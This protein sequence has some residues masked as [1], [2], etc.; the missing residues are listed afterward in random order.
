M[1]KTV[2]NVVSIFLA[3]LFGLSIS[4]CAFAADKPCVYAESV[5]TEAGEIIN[6]PVLIKNNSGIMGTKIT[7]S[8]DDGLEILDVQKGEVFSSG[9]FIQNS[10]VK[11]DNSFDV[12]W[13]SNSANKANGTMFVVTFR[14]SDE[15]KG[16]YN[17]VITYDQDNTFD[18]NYEDVKLECNNAIISVPIEDSPENNRSV[19]EKIVDFF[20]SLWS[21]IVGLFK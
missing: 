11:K 6:V 2:L 12:V 18:E 9:N 10:E 4:V 15:A 13:N 17:I 19:W 3:V 8:Y 1:K 21:K 7:V 20:V 14:L 5:Q 16:D